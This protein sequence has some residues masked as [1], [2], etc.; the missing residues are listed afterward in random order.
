MAGIG[1]SR[2]TAALLTQPTSRPAASAASAALGQHRLVPRVAGHAADPRPVDPVE[3]GRV[4][5]DGHDRAPGRK[6]LDDRPADPAA[7][8]GH[9]VRVH[10]TILVRR[11]AGPARR[12]RHQPMQAVVYT[13]N[14]DP[15]VLELV[16]REVPEPGPGEVR[17]RV[18]VSG[19]N[20]TDWKARRQHSRPGRPPQIPNQ[21]GSGVVD[22][23]G[24]GVDRAV[25]GQRVWLWESA[26]QRPWGTAAEYTVV[27]QR[28]AVLLPAGAS[29]RAGG[30]ARGA[31]PHR[32][33]LPHARR[34]DA[35]PAR[36]R[37]AGGQDRAGPGRGRRG[38]QRRDPAG[39]VGRRPD[40]HHGEQPGEG[41]AG[42]RG[43]GGRHRRLPDPGRAER[44]TQDR[45]A[46][47]GRDRRGLGGSQRRHRRAGPRDARG[48]RDL[49]RR[50]RVDRDDP[51][52]A[53]DGA[54]RALAVRAR[55]HR[56]ERTPRV[57]RSRTSTQRSPTAR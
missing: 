42:G 4:E 33:P 17:V 19:V 40:H 28:Q 9:H 51:D 26:D 18:A 47:R 55:L 36:P 6:P 50:R 1:T 34:V 10:V 46:R 38:R 3:R 11:C 56:A 29:P 37:R 13:R 24:N 44:G 49:R 43:R 32:A 54:E 22:A 2:K 8:T 57:P 16:D 12:G 21:D 27:P 41:P 7:A 25:L 45:A 23:V 15:D 52:P 39:P 48:G 14:G 5:L 53:D 30:R 35:G 31:V 20:P